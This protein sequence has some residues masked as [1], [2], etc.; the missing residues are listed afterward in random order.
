MKIIYEPK[1]RAAEYALLAVNHYKGCKHGCTYCYVP[2]VLRI[3]N[4]EFHSKVE[5]KRDVLARVGADAK[6][7]SGTDR[8]VLLCFACDPYPDCDAAPM[9]T[10]DTGSGRAEIS[11][12]SGNS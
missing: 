6:T 2:G 5:P 3:S 10:L 11:M 4:E 7:L 9:L 8:R 1:A 12:P